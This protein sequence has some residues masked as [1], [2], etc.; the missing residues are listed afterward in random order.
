MSNSSNET[1]ALGAQT[2]QEAVIDGIRAMI[3]SGKYLPGQRMVQDELASQFGVSRT[4]IREALNHLAHEG[5]VTISSYKGA[6]VTK[7][8]YQDLV[9]IYTVRAALESHA[10]YLAAARLDE[11]GITRLE[12]LLTEMR[13][14]F[15][16]KD[17]ERLVSTHEQFHQ[18]IYSA[19]DVEL[20]YNLILRYMGLS[21]IYQRLS[22]SVGRGAHD[23]IHEHI[24]IL[25]MLRFQEAEYASGLIRT[26]LTRTMAE[27]KE[28]ID[29]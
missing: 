4:P 24:D 15:Q 27:L 18:A 19:A 25:Q 28:I 22:L 5:L 16:Q 8:S 1:P 14:A 20:L 9:D 3:L 12:S 6:V 7:F 23:P 2:R 10:T 26:H 17:F 11:D 13:E 21:S 29:K